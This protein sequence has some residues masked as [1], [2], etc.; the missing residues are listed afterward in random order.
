MRCSSKLNSSAYVHLG[1]F[2]F[3]QF[4]QF[5]KITMLLLHWCFELY[6]T[7]KCILFRP[8]KWLQSFCVCGNIARILV[9]VGIRWFSG[10][11]PHGILNRFYQKSTKFVKFTHK[12]THPHSALSSQL[13]RSQMLIWEKRVKIHNMCSTLNAKYQTNSTNKTLVNLK[14]SR[15]TFRFLGK[16]IEVLFLFLIRFHSGEQITLC[17][18]EK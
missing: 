12:H 4:S 5:F 16:K 18:A 3:V 13:N 8:T 7:Y 15:W 6:N 11:C 10:K 14:L 17:N 9:S 1:T 2:R